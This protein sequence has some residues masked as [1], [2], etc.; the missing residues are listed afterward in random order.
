MT[1]TQTSIVVDNTSGADPVFAATLAGA[2]QARGFQVEV[3]EPSPNALFDTAVHMVAEGIA[4]RVTG[5]IPRPALDDVAAVV[6]ESLR[7]RR[8]ERQRVRS[9]PIYMGD[10]PRVLRWVDIFE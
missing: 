2:L 5:A 4:L 1:G 3:R 8:S 6:R 7:T 9:V 10:T